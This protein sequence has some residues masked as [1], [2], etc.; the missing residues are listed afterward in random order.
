[1]GVGELIASMVS[2]IE[3]PAGG[4]FF[5]RSEVSTAGAVACG[6][7]ALAVVWFRNAVTPRADAAMRPT[8]CHRIFM[9]NL[10]FV[11]C[12]LDHIL[13][14]RTPPPGC[15]AGRRS[16]PSYVPPRICLSGVEPALAARWRRDRLHFSRLA[17]DTEDSQ[18]L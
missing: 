5:A 7:A 13:R 15:R 4:A 11:G 12:G 2:G 6:A 18:K 17:D 8:S 3:I 10:T 9:E 14:A 1:M 16:L